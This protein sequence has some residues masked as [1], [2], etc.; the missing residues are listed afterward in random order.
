MG[1]IEW[2]DVTWNPVRGCSRVSEGC[3][4]CYAERQAARFLVTE[5]TS[6]GRVPGEVDRFE[7]GPF[8]GFVE[9]RSA[10][11]RW[12]GKVQLIGSKLADPL[13]WRRPR[14]IFVNSM[15]DLFHEALPDKD[16]AQ[17]FRVMDLSRRHT[18]QVLTKRAKRMAQV[19]PQ[20]V[21]R[22]GVLPNVW[23]G[24]SIE[25]QATADER[26]PHLLSTPAA[27]RFVSYEPAL[28]P[29][30]LW[31]A[32]YSMPDGSLGSAFKWGDGVRWVIAGGESGPGARPVNPDWFRAVRDQCR[33]AGVAFFFKQWGEWL[34]AGQ[35]GAGR[36][37]LNCSDAAER[38]GKK[39]AGRLLDGCEYS[40]FPEV[41]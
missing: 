41:G 40:E 22:Y 8:A 13:R 6:T 28:G 35:D 23:L 25:D 9:R 33:A 12:T 7:S 20:I 26:I 38:V 4:H 10:G 37:V 2:T 16:I 14:K 18:F 36:R 30:D 3:R 17:V 11:P 32:R 39:A 19:M 31:S 34:P 15:S 5:E 21:D 24:V 27:I 29:V 1:A